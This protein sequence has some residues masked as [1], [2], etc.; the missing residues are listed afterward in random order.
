MVMEPPCGISTTFRYERAK[1][2]AMHTAAKVSERVSQPFLSLRPSRNAA[3]MMAAMSSTAPTYRP[4]VFTWS[5]VS[6]LSSRA[7][8]SA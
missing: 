6:Q 5:S 3:A 7:L 1:L 4:T 2:M 8:P